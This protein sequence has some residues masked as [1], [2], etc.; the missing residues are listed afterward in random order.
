MGIFGDDRFMESYQ[1]I[2]GVCFNSAHFIFK[3]EITKDNQTLPPNAFWCHHR[4]ET[5]NRV[6][7]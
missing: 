1:E 5:L 2:L 7:I 4:D 3:N 6:S